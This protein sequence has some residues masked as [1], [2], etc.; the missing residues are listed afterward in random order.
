[1]NIYSCVENWQ[2]QIRPIYILIFIE[3]NQFEHTL[4]ILESFLV[5]SPHP[6]RKEVALYDINDALKLNPN[7]AGAMIR[8]LVT[9][10]A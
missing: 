2:H 9:L 4:S 1:M 7:Y 6:G 10:E 5:F 8:S 3:S